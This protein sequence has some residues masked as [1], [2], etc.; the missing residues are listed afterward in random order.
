[1]TTSITTYHNPDCFTFRYQ[2]S[3]KQSFTGTAM[4]RML[5]TSAIVCAFFAAFVSAAS[6]GEYGNK[7]A[8][9]A[10]LGKEVPT[11]CKVNLVI[12]GKTYC[13]SSESSK[14]LFL[15]DTKGN[16]EKADAFMSTK[17]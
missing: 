7:C 15:E 8:T 16:I 13:F 10:A 11:D 5:K 2:E 12:K 9:A 17:K 4:T 14:S 3:T 1:M 6:A